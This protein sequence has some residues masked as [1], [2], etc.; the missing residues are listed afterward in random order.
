M[1]VGV[2][3]SVARRLVDVKLI[4]VNA[5]TSSQLFPSPDRGQQHVPHV[6]FP[7]IDQLYWTSF[8]SLCSSINI[9]TVF[10]TTRTAQTEQAETKSRSGTEH[11][12]MRCQLYDT[13]VYLTYRVL[14]FMRRWMD[15]AIL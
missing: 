1:K 9:G 14:H 3:E 12:C 2:E 6:E 7:T 4:L 8:I 5:K 11:G 15:D 13:G 10:I